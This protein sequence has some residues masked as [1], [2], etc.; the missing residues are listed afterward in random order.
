[1]LTGGVWW[2][3]KA[4]GER[5][6]MKTG[7]GSSAALVTALVGALVC[8]FLPANRFEES[9]E[10]LEFIHNLAQLSHCFVQRKV[11]TIDDQS[12]DCLVNRVGS[13][14]RCVGAHSGVY[15]QIGSGFD[16][17]A[18]CYGSQRFT[19]FPASIL[20]GFT[21]PESLQPA[22]LRECLTDR[23]KWDVSRRIVRQTP[24]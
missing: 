17:S 18:A 7:M 5:V 22:A 14:S 11:R 4:D 15:E 9:S 12:V 21:S 23:E 8:F 10:D 2:T 1:M 19:R 3:E 20:D 13:R 24:A 6:A 16:V